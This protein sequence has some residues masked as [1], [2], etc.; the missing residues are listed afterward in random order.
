MDYKALLEKYMQLI[1][2]CESVDYI[3]YN[4]IHGVTIPFTKQELEALRELSPHAEH[5]RAI[6]EQHYVVFEN[7]PLPK[8]ETQKTAPPPKE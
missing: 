1:V 6:R 5:Y 2:E 4:G 7:F 8:D 3:D